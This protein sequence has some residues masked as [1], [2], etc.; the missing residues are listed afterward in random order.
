MTKQ[1]NDKFFVPFAETINIIKGQAIS[2]KVVGSESNHQVHVGLML[3]YE[4]EDGYKAG[5]VEESLKILQD[6]LAAHEIICLTANSLVSYFEENLIVDGIMF[7]NF[8]SQIFSKAAAKT[9]RTLIEILQY[10]RH[11]NNAWRLLH[12]YPKIGDK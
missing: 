12:T 9:S 4:S 1:D 2:N 6:C 8:R 7:C 5:Q 3:F 11:K 10:N